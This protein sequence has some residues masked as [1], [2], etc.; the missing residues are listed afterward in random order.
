MLDRI[1]Q[2]Y[3]YMKSLFPLAALVVLVGCSDAP[4]PEAK[5]AP[6]APPKP[7]TGRQAFQQVFPMARAWA[8]DSQPLQIRSIQLSGVPPEKGKA[9]AWEVIFV[10]QS[11]GR[12]RAFTYSVIEAEG[13]LHQGPFGGLEDGWSGSSQ[14]KAFL[15]QAL[16]IDTDAA[17]KTAAANSEAYIKRNPDR[18]V[19]F[20]LD[21]TGRFPD[22]AWRVMWGESV[23]TSD[24]SVFV[25]ASTGQFIERI[26]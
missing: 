8:P 14:Q 13:N 22:P 17:Y 16:K 15:P 5:K 1:K 24:Y 23:G 18:P 6:E 9:G 11:R 4:S 3:L 20:M 19:N 7:V 21:Y 25:D 26:R 12:Q 2:E 10:S